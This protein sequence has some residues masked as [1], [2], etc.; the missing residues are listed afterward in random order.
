MKVRFHRH[1]AERLAERGATEEEVILAV[2][3]GEQFEA[4]FGRTGFRRNVPY[5]QQWRGKC[6]ETK[7]VEV[8]AIHRYDGWLVI[9]VV[10]RYFLGM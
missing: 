7:Q 6:Y 10:T 1:A 9:S 8:F 4:K 5:N 2:E 3:A